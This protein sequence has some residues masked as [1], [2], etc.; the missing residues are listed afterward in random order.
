MVTWGSAIRSRGRGAC[1]L[2]PLNYNPHSLT[3]ITPNPTSSPSTQLFLVYNTYEYPHREE[4]KDSRMAGFKLGVFDREAHLIGPQESCCSTIGRSQKAVWILAHLR[5]IV[6]SIFINSI[7]SLA[8]VELAWS[9]SRLWG[10][11]GSYGSDE[12]GIALLVKWLLI[13]TNQ[14]RYACLRYHLFFAGGEEERREK[15]WR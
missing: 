10:R 4:E 2:T 3:L 14:N 15:G 7:I 9:G 12:G 13:I 6:V 8:L 11:P 5:I 1:P